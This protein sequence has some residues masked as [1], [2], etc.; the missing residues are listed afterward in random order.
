MTNVI[1]VIPAR[2]GST[3]F[4]GKPLALIRGKPMILWVLEAAKGSQL[5]SRTLVAT[6][7]ERIRKVVTEAGGE[8]VMTASE[9]PSGTDRIHAAIGGIPADIV[10]NIQGDEPLIEPS[11]I[12]D[13]VRPLV[14]DGELEMSTLATDLHASELDNPNVVKVLVDRKGNA[15]YFSRFP[16]PYSRQTRPEKPVSLRHLGL[17]AY[18]RGFLDRFCALP[19]SALERAEALEQLRALEDGAR[20]RVVKTS[21]LSLGV[22]TPE[23][24]A[25]IEACLAP[26]NSRPGALT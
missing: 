10:V 20:I 25:K 3:R 7:D 16:L 6:D 21:S 5:L 15:L 14:E 18:R 23:D 19:P 11:R 9:L 24:L 12:D 8:A 22:D 17:Y 2:F 26:A 13:L 1:G 4:P